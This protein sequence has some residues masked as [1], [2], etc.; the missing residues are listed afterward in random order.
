M[1]KGI[2]DVKVG[3]GLKGDFFFFDSFFKRADQSI[4][5]AIPMN[6]VSSYIFHFY[7][8]S[9]TSVDQNLGL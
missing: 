4:A 6:V 1:K 5:R 2:W 3:S 8:L 7:I 9:F